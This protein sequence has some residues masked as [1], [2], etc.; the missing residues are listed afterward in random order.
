MP[1]ERDDISIFI[2]EDRHTN[3]AAPAMYAAEQM[4]TGR[5]QKRKEKNKMGCLMREDAV[6]R[7]VGRIVESSASQLIPPHNPHQP[8][9]RQRGWW[10]NMDAYFN[11]EKTFLRFAQGVME[12]NCLIDLKVANLILCN[13]R[14]HPYVVSIASSHQDFLQSVRRVLFAC[15][16]RYTPVSDWESR[17]LFKLTKELELLSVSLDK[18]SIPAAQE[19][20]AEMLDIHRR[21]LAGHHDLMQHTSAL[22]D[23]IQGKMAITELRSRSPQ[24]HDLPI[25]QLESPV[26][27]HA[28]HYE[29][30]SLEELALTVAEQDWAKA[31][32]MAYLVLAGR[33]DMGEVLYHAILDDEFVDFATDLLT[34]LGYKPS[35]PTAIKN[36]PEG[37]CRQIRFFSVMPRHAYSIPEGMNC[38][39]TRI[40]LAK[41]CSGLE[42]KLPNS[43]R[44]AV[45]L[46]RW[47]EQKMA[48]LKQKARKE[49]AAEEAKRKA[50][51]QPS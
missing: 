15:G 23:W 12:R 17:P 1:L 43:W 46:F 2:E 11:A 22:M 13:K 42:F 41:L 34:D 18:I 32:K 14:N 49:K 48:E 16:I 6:V 40:K 7:W 3:A 38:E 50:P 21:F 4:K 5:Q 35:P 39:E 36:S 33:A 24:D 20:E 27:K 19:T 45:V 47:G 37:L 25:P 26:L 10:N 51:H 30:K 9:Y 29:R 28:S 44:Q 31:E 8:F